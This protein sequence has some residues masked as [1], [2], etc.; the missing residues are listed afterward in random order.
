MSLVLTACVALRRLTHRRGRDEG[1]HR[2]RRGVTADGFVDANKE[3]VGFD[4][5]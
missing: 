1:S 3:I 2:H 5:D 4:I